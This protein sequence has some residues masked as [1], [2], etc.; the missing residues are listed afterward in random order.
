MEVF[1]LFKNVMND[2]MYYPKLYLNGQCQSICVDDGFIFEN[3][4]T[5]SDSALSML[6]KIHHLI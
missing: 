3:L 2:H 1:F 6:L 4:G 5:K